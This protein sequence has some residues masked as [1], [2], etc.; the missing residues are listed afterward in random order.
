[1]SAMGT[2]LPRLDGPAK[3]TGAAP[4]AFEHTGPGETVH[5]HPITAT[6]ARGAVTSMDTSEAQTHPGV[7]AVLTPWNAP[8]LA[9]TSEREYAICQDVEVLY[10]GQPIGMVLAETAEV[11]RWAQS[12]VR[13]QYDEQPHDV[14]FRTDHPDTYEPEVVNGGYPPT[15]TTGEMGP[16]VARAQTDGHLVD[17][18]YSTPEEHN[19]PMEPHAV[20]A[21]WDADAPL[22]TM[23][24]STQSPHGVASTLAPV[25]LSLIHI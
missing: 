10:R 21:H 5:L 16:A 20:S 1:M 17:Q 25:F 4:Y 13:V 19:N 3:V 6:I 12:V 22:L 2:S 23:Y 14:A 24:D 18:T 9:D 8:R 7:L 11:A 15:S